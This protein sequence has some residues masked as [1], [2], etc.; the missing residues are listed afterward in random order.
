MQ[1]VILFE[2]QIQL[3]TVIHVG[4]MEKALD[5]IFDTGAQTTS[6]SYSDSIY[7]LNCRPT[8]N[9]KPLRGFASTKA[10]ITYGIKVDSLTLGDIILYDKELF[11]TND[12]SVTISLLGMDILS[13]LG[14]LYKGFRHILKR[15]YAKMDVVPV[16]MQQ[17]E[18]DR[19]LKEFQQ[20][21]YANHVR[22]MEV[23]PKVEMLYSDL[24]DCVKQALS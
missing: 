16:N 20:S 17:I 23:L 19:I 13:G 5:I 7:F 21:S 14:F 3:N 6:L 15:D 22:V 12:P 4:G 11:I 9:V 24:K 8:G 1:E 2:D 10:C 18:V